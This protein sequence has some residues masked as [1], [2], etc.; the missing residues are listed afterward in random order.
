MEKIK[1]LEGDMKEAFYS[2]KIKKTFE[3]T[4]QNPEDLREKM[5]TYDYKKWN[6]SSM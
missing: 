3:R 6:D 4:S 2:L 5:G 1:E